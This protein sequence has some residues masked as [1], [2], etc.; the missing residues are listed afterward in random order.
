[1]SSESFIKQVLTGFAEAL[2]PLK[3]A[4]ASPQTFASFLGGFGWTLASND[5]NKITGSLGGLSTL[6]ANP[7][8]MS[9]EQLAGDLVS[10]AN[11]IRSIASSGANRFPS[12]RKDLSL[13][14]W[15]PSHWQE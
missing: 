10:A 11:V 1:M 14:I 7:S 15:L 2:A 9:L 6:A 5:L 12:L 3:A 13:P 4:I 8:S